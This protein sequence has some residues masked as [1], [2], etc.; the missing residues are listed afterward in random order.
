VEHLLRQR[1]LL[2]EFAA[3]GCLFIVSA[4]E[5]LSDVVLANLGK[6]HTRRDVRTVVDLVRR[7]GIVLRPSLVP[8]TPWATLDDYLE[9]L[10]FVE[11]EGLV[12]QID[13]V[14]YTIRLLVPPGSSLLSRSAMRPFLG[15]LD[16]AA[17][18][19]RWTHPDPRMDDLQRDVAALVEEAARTGE[20][21]AATFQ[22]IRAAAARRAG[23]AVP[24]PRLPPPERP[25]PA[26][27]TEPW[28]C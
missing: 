13:P 2:A 10:E 5:S 8:F 23:V 4:V 19:Y 1:A 25:I 12:D 24:M 20:D 27:L 26:R 21:P 14:Q 15:A 6:G 17:L 11:T 18:T 7:A 22:R 9:L 16:R 28:F 3:T